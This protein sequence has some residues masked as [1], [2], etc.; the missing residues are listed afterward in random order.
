M[1]I[2][3]LLILKLYHLWYSIEAVITTNPYMYYWRR[4]W[5][6]TPVFCLENPIDKGAW[7]VTQSMASQRVRYDLATK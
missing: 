3:P 1:E 5:Q 6:L 4:K 2:T 7:Q